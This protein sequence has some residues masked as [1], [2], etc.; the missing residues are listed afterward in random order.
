M[1]YTVRKKRTR[2]GTL[3]YVFDTFINV[4]VSK[5]YAWPDYAD[6]LAD[7]FNQEALCA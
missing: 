6:Q 2:I 1:R 7:E 5:G 4:F 3:F